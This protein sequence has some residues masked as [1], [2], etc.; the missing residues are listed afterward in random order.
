[1]K[2]FSLAL[3]CHRVFHPPSDT[4]F[5]IL[6]SAISILF[7]ILH[8]ISLMKLFNFQK[9]YRKLFGV[10]LF[11]SFKFLP[12]FSVKSL[13]SKPTN[14]THYKC[15]HNNFPTIIWIFSF[16][17]INSTSFPLKLFLFFFKEK[18]NLHC[19]LFHFKYF[20]CICQYT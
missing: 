1:M 5:L 9:K 16:L 7:L 20:I 14:N 2:S 18:V 11:I 6:F 15:G 19:V 13:T 4:L 8:S 17:L 10:H 12:L 3:T